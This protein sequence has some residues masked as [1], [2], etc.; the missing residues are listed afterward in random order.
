MPATSAP[1]KQIER[2]Y[3]CHPSAKPFHESCAQVK[4]LWGP[5]GSG[6]SLA[7]IMEFVFLCLESDVPVRGIVLRESYKQLRD[8][9]LKTW[10]EWLGSC[11]RYLQSD[12]NLFLTLPNYRGEVLTHEMHFRHCRRVEEA[13]DLLSTEYA[14]IWFEEPVPAYQMESGVIGAGLPE[15]MFDLALTRQRQA[16]MHRLHIVLT[17]NPPSKFH[18]CDKRFLNVPRAKLEEI[19]FAHFWQPPYENARN[20][21]P[22]YYTR[23]E[24]QLGD[25]M[26]RR[27][28]KGERVTQYAGER[29][30]PLF[31]EHVHFVEDLK[32]NSN[33][34]L[35]IGFDFGRTPVALI[36]QQLTNGRV[37]EL[38]EVQLWGAGTEDLA[39]QL[40][41]VLHD[42]FPGFTTY[43]CWGDPA[44]ADPVQ[45]DEKTCFSIL[46]NKGF[47][48]LPGA[49][50]WQ[51]R[52]EAVHQRCERMGDDGKPA[53]LVDRS[54]CPLLSEGLLGGY[55]YPKYASGLI[56]NR[57]IKNDF[58]HVCDALQY[59]MTGLFNVATGEAKSRPKKT[60]G[61][62]LDPFSRQP[63]G[64][65]DR[66]W[67]ST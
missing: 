3:N 63:F 28:V 44:G 26:V 35:T 50:D 62:R 55:V 24:Q 25:D 13:S 27:V 49:R 56:G 52:W 48:L 30:F 34:P 67:M 54:R 46:R 1:S 5:M 42:E 57:P 18:W 2:T 6:K 45:T 51:S 15:G 40:C 41:N 21:P 8:S 66:S 14:F 38:R 4:A 39:E 58:S 33:L 11:S 32:P 17:F 64:R 60:P 65:G 7:A 59:K 9:T 61:L 37:I 20:L 47:H 31:H 43:R 36:G 19:G 16:G 29:V 23:L 22:N 12:H 53:I 10:M